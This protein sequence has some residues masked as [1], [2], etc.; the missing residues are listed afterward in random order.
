VR[1]IA[2]E[3]EVES[4]G[5]VWPLFAGG[6]YVGQI[7]SCTWSPDF[8]TNVAIGMVARSHWEPGSRLEVETPNGRRTA[9]VQSKFWI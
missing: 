1:P 4:C 9:I 5:S 8:N 7:T 6:A 2:I 3:G